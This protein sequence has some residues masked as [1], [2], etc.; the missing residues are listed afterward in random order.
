MP[1]SQKTNAKKQLT[2]AL[3]ELLHKK[4]FQKISVNELCE[5]ARV[6]R[7]AFYSNFENKYQLLA[8][9]LE[10]TTR[11]VDEL[12]R[13]STPEEF[14]CI[15]LNAI[16]KEKR[17]FYNAFSA[18]LEEET[19]QILYQFFERHLSSVLQEKISRGAVFPEPLSVVSSF[20]IGGIVTAT[21]DWIKSGYQL[22]TETVAACLY[23]LTRDIF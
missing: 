1:L 15:T 5:A 7:S 10:S 9:C 17:L 21:A 20:Y 19:M 4:A 13:F 6:S 18:H 22:S 11:G 3:I 14:Y 12:L 23:Q 2:A 8:F 16:Q